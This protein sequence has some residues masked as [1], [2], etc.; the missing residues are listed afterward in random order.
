MLLTLGETVGLEDS[1]TTTTAN[2]TRQARSR[3]IH[4]AYRRQKC[5]VVSDLSLMPILS[6]V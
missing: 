2:M 1:I 4:Y 5:P 3:G 6:A